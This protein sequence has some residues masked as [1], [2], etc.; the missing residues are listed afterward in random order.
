MD[1]AAK[2]EGTQANDQNDL[3]CDEI[4]T[5]PPVGP[6]VS[7][8]SSG[9]SPIPVLVELLRPLPHLTSEDPEA[10]MRLFIRLDEVHGLGLVADR[11]FI[12]RIL[13]LVPGS[14]LT[15][16]NCLR[17]G[18]SWDDYSAFIE[19]IL[20]HL[21][22]ERM[23]R[24]LVVYHFHGQGQSLRVYIEQFFP[25]A[26]FLQYGASEQELV[27]RLAMNFHPDILTEASFFYR[28]RKLRKLYQ[29]VGI[30][31]ERLAVAQKR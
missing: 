11:I 4:I 19:R 12:T 27:Q 13:P 20:P 6:S 5:D 8:G 16:G 28:P 26:I 30:L 7:R 14:L 21:V 3:V 31:E 18:T 23:I 25:A 2:A 24:D 15:L 17:A 22:R 1:N 9:D 29:A 10:I